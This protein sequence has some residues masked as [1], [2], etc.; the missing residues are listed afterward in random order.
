M[1]CHSESA[2]EEEEREKLAKQNIRLTKQKREI[3]DQILKMLRDSGSDILESDDFVNTLEE[4]K[5]ITQDITHKLTV[6]KHMED[7][8]EENRKIFK[9]VAQHGAR[10]YFAVQDLHMLDPMYVF[11]MKW[12]RDLFLQTF[13]VDNDADSDDDASKQDASDSSVLVNA[14]QL[15]GRFAGGEITKQQQKEIKQAR[16]VELKQTFREILYRAVCMSLFERHK[17]LFAFFMAL[18]IYEH[19]FQSD[20]TFAEKL[21]ELDKLA[22]TSGSGKL[23]DS[24]MDSSRISGGDNA[25]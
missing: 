4:S 17:L 11:S 20:A 7:R 5:T 25:S 12:F 8:I 9:P 13:K 22:D 16:V 15:K 18:K 10:L 14:K 24:R 21:K 1:V 2:K 19:G 6:A 3:V 23:G